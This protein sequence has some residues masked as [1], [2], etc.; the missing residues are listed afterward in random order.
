M[1]KEDVEDLKLLMNARVIDI[2]VNLNDK[3]DYG[4]DLVFNNGYTLEVYIDKDVAGWL[5]RRE[6]ED[7]EP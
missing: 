4:F 1:N 7:D 2:K 5:V 3:D 6:N